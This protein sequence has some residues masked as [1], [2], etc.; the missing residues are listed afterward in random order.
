MISVLL[1]KASSLVHYSAQ[2]VKAKSNRFMGPCQWTTHE[3]PG[4]E[5]AIPADFIILNVSRT[6]KRMLYLLEMEVVE[7]VSEQSG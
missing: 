4:L 7:N 1:H 5:K 2:D 3:C 6:R